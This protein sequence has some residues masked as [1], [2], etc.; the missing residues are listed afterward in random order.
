MIQL[1]D[2]ATQ[3]TCCPNAM[4]TN[5]IHAFPDKEPA[6]N[7]ADICALGKRNKTATNLSATI[8]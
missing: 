5:F 1:V 6:S 3:C 8:F 4:E 2:S 7:L